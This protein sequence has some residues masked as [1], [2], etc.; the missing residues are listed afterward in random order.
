MGTAPKSFAQ[1]VIADHRHVFDI[2][3]DVGDE[4]AAALPTGLLTEHGA[5]M[6]GDFQAGQTVL[7]TGA[8][9]SVGLI[10]VQIAQ[11]LGAATVL[12]TSTTDAKHAALTRA[13]ADVA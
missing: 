4:D 5:L 6:I 11:A 8:S 10:G 2:P 9:S 3:L 1:Y 7:I 13:G 12:A